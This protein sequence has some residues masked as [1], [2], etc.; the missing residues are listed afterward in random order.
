MSVYSPASV[1]PSRPFRVRVKVPA[2]KAPP[3]PMEELMSIVRVELFARFSAPAVVMRVLAAIVIFP[4]A[5]AP[6]EVRASAPPRMSVS[7]V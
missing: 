1:I 5:V 6:V 3:T 4:R 2:P 7:P